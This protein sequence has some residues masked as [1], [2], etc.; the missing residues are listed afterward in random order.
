MVIG[1]LHLFLLLPILSLSRAVNPGFKARLTEH[2][3][4]YANKVAI[5]A[6]EK[7]I[8]S[9]QIPDISG[10]ASGIKYDI[11]DIRLSLSNPP[12]ST[13]TLVP[14]KGLHWSATNVGVNLAATFHYKKSFI[15]DSGS[16]T[17]AVTGVNFDL[18]IDMGNDSNGR[19]TLTSHDCFV[20]VSS[21][22]IQFHGS[23]A[24]LYN[25]LKGQVEDI[26]KSLLNQKMCQVV[27]SEINMDANKQLAK[28]KVTASL[29]NRFL[30]DY[31]LISAP[32]FNK[33]YLETWHEGEITWLSAP[34]EHSSL[35]PPIMADPQDTSSMV[36]LALSD[37]LFNTA[38][39]VAQKHG[40]LAYNLTQN[41]LPEASR[42]VLNTSCSG[43]I[44]KCVGSL[45]PAIGKNYPNGAVEL[46]M[47]STVSP[48]LTIT[49]SGLTVIGEGNIDLYA[50]VPSRK[51]RPFLVTLTATL[52]SSVSVSI[53]N[54]LLYAK[55]GNF[56]L[57]LKS[58]K[59][60]VGPISDFFLDFLT[61]EAIN[62]VVIPKLNEFGAKGFPLPVADDVH[63]VNTTLALA[64]DTII[65]GT[66]IQYASVIQ[67]SSYNDKHEYNSIKQT[68]DTLR[69]VPYGQH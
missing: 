6:L 51:D 45:I 65:V 5:E 14:N 29:D 68:D 9:L 49:S 35:P 61:K 24:W 1:V 46:R 32:I 17:A 38:A 2:G 28:L 41:D 18:G 47:S 53:K 57:K 10:S 56:D 63:F 21:V 44:P 7:N 26:V 52:T 25:L 64:Q 4:E 59:S 13:I 3:L 34:E 12:S 22:Q 36:Y 50:D 58:G 20:H 31:R 40:F 15:S 66:D 19:P 8:A 48:R 23:M 42:G 37:Y 16:L 54:E 27:T 62:I 67:S 43:F 55:V 39:D 33:G 30:L 60:D 69:F 11:R